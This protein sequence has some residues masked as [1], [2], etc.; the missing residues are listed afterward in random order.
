MLSPSDIE[1]ALVE[2]ATAASSSSSVGCAA[3]HSI[4]CL[5]WV[6]FGLVWGGLFSAACGRWLAWRRWPSVK[7]SDFVDLHWLFWIRWANVDILSSLSLYFLDDIHYCV[8]LPW[9]CA[10]QFDSTLD[11]PAAEYCKTID[12]MKPSLTAMY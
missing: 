2:I 12:N 3:S 4:I 11:R 6:W 7:K 9:C 10:D 5:W 1:F 8:G